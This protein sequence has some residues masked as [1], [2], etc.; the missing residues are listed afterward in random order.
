MGI[1][2]SSSELTARN[3]NEKT[4]MKKVKDSLQFDGNRYEVAVP[5]KNEQPSLINN[6]CQ[7]EQRLYSTEQKLSK[8]PK[9]VVAY[10]QVIDEY[11]QK[12]YIRRVPDDEPKPESEWLLA[13]FPVIQP[14]RSTTKVRI[15]F[16]ASA[17]FRGKSL[18]SEALPGPK[19]QA[20]L[21]DILVK[22]RKELVP[23]VG[24]IN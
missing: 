2:P 22:F 15:V 20:N 17:K 1:I 10:Q 19:L 5:W 18:N 6:R 3:P 11:L 9:V 4:A 21:V 16:D 12:E 8:Y 14:D 23:S 24:T 13:H 7:A